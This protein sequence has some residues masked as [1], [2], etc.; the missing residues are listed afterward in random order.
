MKVTW[1][2]DLTAQASRKVAQLA[3]LIGHGLVDCGDA[4]IEKPEP[5]LLVGVEFHGRYL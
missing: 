2:N 4:K 1:E 3:L 5:S